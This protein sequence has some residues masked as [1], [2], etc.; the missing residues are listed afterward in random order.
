MH[1]SINADQLLRDLAL[2]VARNVVGANRP[3]NEIIAG[4]GLTASEYAAISTNPQFKR[5]LAAYEKELT[6]NGF[7]FSAKAKVLAEASLPTVYHMIHD[8]DTPAAVR[9]Q[10]IAD[11]VEWAELKPKNNNLAPAGPGFSITINIPSTGQTPSQTIVLEAESP[12]KPS[13][14]DQKLTISA[15]NGE[16]PLN[17]G[18]FDLDSAS[19]RLPAPKITLAEPEDYEYAGDDVL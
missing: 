6:E 7:S 13:E 12:E 8:Q 3:I 18:D 19:I 17:L 15:E 14:T 11:L 1:S 5:Y 2:A 4:E 9:R 16:K 10:L